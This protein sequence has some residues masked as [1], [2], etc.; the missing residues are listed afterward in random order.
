MRRLTLFFT[1]ST[2]FAGCSSLLSDGHDYGK[3]RVEAVTPEGEPVAGLP[4]TLYQATR[5][6]AYAATD[7]H[8]RY[9]FEFVPFGNHGVLAGALEG[10]TFTS[11]SVQD[12]L[13]IGDNGGELEVRFTLSQCQGAIGITVMDQLGDPVP[14][15]RLVLYSDGPEL[16]RFAE[17]GADGTAEYLEVPCG[18]YGI[19]V[20][21]PEGYSVVEGQGSSFRDGIVVEDAGRAQVVFTIQRS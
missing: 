11:P 4:L 2:L 20:D 10:Y 5:P 12:G 7:V 14:G 16:N 18:E 1:L 17:S 15:A 8:G 21:P 3:I 19:S 9:V 6:I 13:I